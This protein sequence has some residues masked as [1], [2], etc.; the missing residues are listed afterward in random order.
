MT[1]PSRSAESPPP[2]VVHPA[3]AARDPP[4]AAIAA[5]TAVA[6]TKSR[7]ESSIVPPFLPLYPSLTAIAAAEVHG[8]QHG[9]QSAVRRRVPQCAGDWA[10]AGAKQNAS[11][12]RRVTTRPSWPVPLRSWPGPFP[13]PAR[14]PRPPPGW[15]SRTAARTGRSQCTPLGLRWVR[16]QNG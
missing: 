16:R 3:M 10:P 14:S 15:R 5:L 9:R 12:P 1:A 6:F 2:P 4:A 13:D 11:P 8:Y 7:L